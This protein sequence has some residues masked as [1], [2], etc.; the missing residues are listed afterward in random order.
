MV[1]WRR[2]DFARSAFNFSM[3][4]LVAAQLDIN[5]NNYCRTCVRDPLRTNLSEEFVGSTPALSLLVVSF[6]LSK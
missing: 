4:T 1:K 5:Y 6:S 2:G 3:Y